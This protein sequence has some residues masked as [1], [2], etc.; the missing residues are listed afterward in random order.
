MAPEMMVFE[1]VKK[2]ITEEECKDIVKKVNEINQKLNEKSESIDKFAGLTPREI[3]NIKTFPAAM[4][5]DKPDSVNDFLHPYAPNLTASGTSR[6][7]IQENVD[8]VIDLASV[9]TYQHD[10]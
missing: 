8:E 10:Q 6:Y 2:E 5:F 1:M 9:I 4:K 7:S 3:S